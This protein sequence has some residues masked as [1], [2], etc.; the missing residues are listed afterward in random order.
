MFGELARL[1]LNDNWQLKQ[2]EPE[3]P[4][5]DDF[6]LDQDWL[7][8][9]VPGTVHQALLDAKLIPDPFEDFNEQKVQWVGEVDW[10]YRRE[11][12]VSEALLTQPYL[13]L[14]FDGLDTFA[15]IWLN[16]HLVA[17]SENMFIPLRLDA[18]PFLQAGSNRLE[19]LFESALRRGQALEKQ[20]GPKPAWNTDPS[21]LYVRKAQYHY[22]W[23][24]G[25]VLITA[26]LWR[27]VG[28]EAY[29][30][31][32]VQLDCLAEVNQ[33]LD[34]A[35]VLVTAN[36][37]KPDSSLTVELN[38][39][40]PHGQQIES[41]SLTANSITE[42]THVFELAEPQ[43]WWPNGYGAAALYRLEAIVR[44]ESDGKQI[45]REEKRTGL[46]RL[47]LVQEPFETEAGTSFYFEINN[48]AIFAG[49]VNW[50]P[51]DSFTP[52]ITSERYD[53]WLELAAAAHLT[54]LR[55]W[56][57]GIYE[58]DRF[59][60]RCDELGL[61]VW[62][63]FMFGCGIYPAH[64]EFLANVQAEAE[65]VLTRLR[66][67][68]AIVIWCANNEDYSIATENFIY[69]P[70]FDGDFTTT[71]FAGR[72]IYEKLLPEVCARVDPSR[73]YW[74][75]SPYNQGL[76]GDAQA[77]VGDFHD[78]TVWHKM[79]DYQLYPTHKGRFI[80]EFGMQGW[81]ERQTLSKMTASTADSLRPDSA[82]IEFH[83]KAQGGV[84]R[85]AGYVAS[86]LGNLAST[87]DLDA[88][89]Y[90]T[91]LIQAEAMSY[92]YGGWRRRWGKAGERYTGGALVWQLN[93]CWPSISWAIA[94]YYL[95]PKAAYYVIKRKLAPIV[96]DISLTDGKAELWAVNASQAVLE[97]TLEIEH[98]TLQ[99]ELISQES[100]LVRLEP[101]QVSE[102]GDKTVASEPASIIAARLLVDGQVVA[103]ATG[104]PQ[105]F[106]YYQLSD[107]ELELS[108]VNPST[109]CLSVTR[110]AKGVWLSTPQ[111]DGVIWEDNMLDLVPGDLQ[112]IT[113]TGLSQTDVIEVNWLGKVNQL[114]A[115]NAALD[116]KGKDLLKNG[117][118]NEIEPLTSAH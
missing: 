115:T 36:L 6:A 64:D 76:L 55:V 5:P 100:Q 62:Q 105:P 73:P 41:V 82:A 84:S 48:Q 83:N 27:D 114:P 66:H 106:K 110:P 72:H 50:I 109:I 58:A 45:D 35:H 81:P 54:M 23:D 10:L 85:L 98:W 102:L 21:R 86:N 13:D 96:L 74:P 107:P 60:D 99:G 111:K 30:N 71:A 68:P 42:F 49:G 112:F 18:K 91:Q 12:E 53:Q 79:I 92:A 75:G 77:Q 103:R 94:D 113:V 56:G 116:H 19:I 9:P 95:R 43:L 89:I 46:R 52:R 70:A 88:Y 87:T 51:A 31:R 14:C 2:R 20:Y 47:K 57:G 80:S 90:A 39:F 26:G 16:G 25:P 118:A 65:T 78:W 34:Q 93:D 33:S 37:A 69:D 29:S 4:L 44:S 7:S 67:H 32:I 17:S 97:A 3:R 104:W 117:L 59:Y 24:W 40:D 28:L 11:F 15:S 101:G 61:L 63:D 38:F 1:N 22:G 8:V 108:W